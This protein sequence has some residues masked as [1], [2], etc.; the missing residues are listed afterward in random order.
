MHL[1]LVT[2]FLSYEKSG[3]CLGSKSFLNLGLFVP[4]VS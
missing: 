2:R 1:E 4:K 3:K